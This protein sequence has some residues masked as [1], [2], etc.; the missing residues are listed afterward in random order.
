MRLIYVCLVHKCKRRFYTITLRNFVVPTL[1]MVGDPLS[2]NGF[3]SPNH[4]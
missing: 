2:G 1:S 3:G 4:I